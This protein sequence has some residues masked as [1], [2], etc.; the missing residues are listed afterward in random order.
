MTYTHRSIVAIFGCDVHVSLVASFSCD[1][2]VSLVAIFSCDV[3][4]SLV[5]MLGRSLPQN[6][7][8]LRVRI[9]KHG[10]RNFLVASDLSHYYDSRLLLPGD[11]EFT[12]KRQSSHNH[13]TR[14]VNSIEAP[15]MTSY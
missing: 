9:F 5:A 4:A 8:A 6:I 3:H 10:S 2:H 12:K 11:S 13:V 1:V 7:F 14:N 15:I